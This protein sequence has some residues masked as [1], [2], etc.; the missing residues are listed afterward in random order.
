MFELYHHPFSPASRTIRLAT[1]EREEEIHLREADLRDVFASPI[2]Q[3]AVSN[4]VPSLHNDDGTLASGLWGITEYL[5]DLG[6]LGDL[7]GNDLVSKCEIR[8]LIHCFSSDFYHHVLTPL[9]VER[10]L[11]RLLGRGAPDSRL[12]RKSFTHLTNYLHALG[13]LL[14]QRRYLAGDSFSMADI[15]ASSYLSVIDYFGDVPWEKSQDARD[16]Y[17]RI[18]SR[19]TFRPLLQDRVEKL[20]CVPHYPDLE[21]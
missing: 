9:L 8:R 16:W 3:T 18:K 15:A 2:T 5:N 19:P 17:A 4:M 20:P 21:F 7:M 1:A 6:H 11:G 10:S 14:G 13:H 12:I